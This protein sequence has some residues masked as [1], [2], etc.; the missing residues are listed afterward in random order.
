MDLSSCD[1]DGNH[2][3][4]IKAGESVGYQERKKRKTTNA[5]YLTDKQVLPLTMSIPETGNHHD[6][7]E[8]KTHG[9]E[10]LASLKNTNISKKKYKRLYYAK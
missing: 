2:T 6:L 8:V 5:L 3:P 1:L 4:A 9:G 10:I 7:F